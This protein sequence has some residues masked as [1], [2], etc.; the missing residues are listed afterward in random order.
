VG[1]AGV[2]GAWRA[3][4]HPGRRRVPAARLAEPE[5]LN[6]SLSGL[7]PVGSFRGAQP[8]AAMLAAAR[9]SQAGIVVVGDYDADG[10]TA[11]ALT[12][13]CLRALGYAHVSYLVPNRFEFGYGLSPPVA[14]L[15][16]RGHPQLLITVDNGIT[17]VEGV[18]RARELGMEVIITDH[19]LPGPRLPAALAM[20][21]PNLPEEPFASKHLSGVGVAFYLMAALARELDRR[22]QVNYA[23]AQPA[24]AGCL[25]LV[26][27]GTVADLVRLDRNN[28]ILVSEGLRRVRARQTRAGI[29]SL[30]AAA[31]RDTAAARSADLAF[32]IAPR[33]NAA[34]R[35]TDMSLGVDCLLA[36][37]P[38]RARELA[39]RLDALNA[40]RQDLQTRMEAEALASLDRMADELRGEGQHAYCLFDKGWHEGIVGLV[41]S[42][43]KER[44]G[45]PVVAF[46]P[47]EESGQLKGSARS[48]EGVHIRDVLATIA[49]RGEVSG[50]N[51][52]GHAMAA[53]VRLPAGA[54]PVFREALAREVSRQLAGP[55]PGQVLWTDGPLEPCDL[56]LELA[57][58]LQ[59]AGPWGQGFQEPMFD[60]EL[61]VVEQKVL[62]EQHLR[63]M[64]RHPSGGAPVE[65]IAFRQARSIGDR[66]RFVY[67]LGVNEFGGRRRL[68]LVVEHLQSA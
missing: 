66:G 65:A 63:L 5:D 32:A 34:G 64:L 33:L 7:L 39:A 49:A 15:A 43:L 58:T 51:F 46:A 6:P 62:R 42:R 53:G 41:A 9:Q 67:R 24:I 2:L 14:E 50:M 8:A 68:Q 18:A 61:Q 35:L 26:A 56:Q 19:H 3:D 44:T 16:A 40:A 57:E 52:G 10:A 59:F 47:G 36:T 31:G 13:S 30:F 12:V 1:P 60:N 22:G 25:D 54:L 23:E 21:N 45:R 17:S 55:D 27:L 38:A 11:V 4:L 28:R 48:V 29:A 20:V 37:D